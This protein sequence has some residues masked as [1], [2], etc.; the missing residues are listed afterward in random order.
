MSIYFEFD[1]IILIKSVMA[2]VAQESDVAPGPL[3]NFYRGN[4]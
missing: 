2:I 3:V 1:T 4:R